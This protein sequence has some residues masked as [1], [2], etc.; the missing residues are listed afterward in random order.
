MPEEIGL[1]PL[2]EEGGREHVANA[3]NI[4]TGLVRG[5][6][7]TDDDKRSAIRAAMVR[8]ARA[9]RELERGNW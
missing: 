2:N 4:L 3:G 8:L 5:M 7:D 1:Y 9:R 6:F